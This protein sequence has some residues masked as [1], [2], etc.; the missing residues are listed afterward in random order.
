MRMAALR[1][2]ACTGPAGAKAEMKPKYQMVGWKHLQ[3]ALDHPPA[4]KALGAAHQEEEPQALG[5]S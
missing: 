4:N 1:K 2:Q 5:Q 3:A